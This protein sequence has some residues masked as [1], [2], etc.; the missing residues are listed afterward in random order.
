MQLAYNNISK[1]ITLYISDGVGVS[2]SQNLLSIFG[3][4]K[5]SEY[6]FTSGT[7][8]ADISADIMGGF[9]ALYIYSNIVENTLVGD[10]LVPLLRVVPL[11]HRASTYSHNFQSFQHI[12]YQKVVAA[13]TDVIEINIR[14][15]NGVL[16]PFSNGKVIITLHFKRIG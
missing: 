10:T 16:V 6:Y 8:K 1:S 12:Q 15:D 2:F 7:H 13:Q 4:S 11:E 14:R 9:H 3:F 5:S